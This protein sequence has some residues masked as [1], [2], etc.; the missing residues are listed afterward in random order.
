MVA[1]AEWQPIPEAEGFVYRRRRV[2]MEQLEAEIR[3]AAVPVWNCIAMEEETR[4]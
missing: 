3:E 1:K 2:T 4:C